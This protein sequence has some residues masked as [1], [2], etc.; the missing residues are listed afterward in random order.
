MEKLKEEKMHLIYLEYKLKVGSK[1]FKGEPK[2]SL[3]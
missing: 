3:L 2:S 1:L